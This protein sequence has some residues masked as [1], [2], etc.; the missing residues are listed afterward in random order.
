MKAEES[1]DGT[2]FVFH[3]KKRRVLVYIY[4]Q[5][6]GHITLRTFSYRRMDMDGAVGTEVD[7]VG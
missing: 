1:V 3:F 7:F 2:D 6:T 4:V 5:S